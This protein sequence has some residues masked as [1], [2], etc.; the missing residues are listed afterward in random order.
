MLCR[1][2]LALSKMDCNTMVFANSDPI[3]P[4]A[5]RVV[6]DIMRHIG[7]NDPVQESYS[8]FM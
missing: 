8:H 4:G 5:A 2:V 1:E 3:T 6:G 7:E